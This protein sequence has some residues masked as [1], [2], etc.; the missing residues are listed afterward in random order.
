MIPAAASMALR[1]LIFEAWTDLTRRLSLKLKALGY[2]VA[3]TFTGGTA[4]KL[5][6]LFYP[7]AVIL[8]LGTP[9]MHGYDVALPL[10][11]TFGAGMTIIGIS[12]DGTAADRRRSK[13][14]GCN[15]H[16]LK[17]ANPGELHRLLQAC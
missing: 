15:H 17:P 6:E 11:E 7:D 3:T 1:I 10:R 16:L 8:D 14:T 2:D 13:E 4:V 5:A 9:E 12:A